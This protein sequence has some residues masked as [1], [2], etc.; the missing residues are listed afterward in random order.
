MHAAQKKVTRLSMCSNASVSKRVNI[1]L[2]A[3]ELF[4]KIVLNV[5]QV[6]CFLGPEVNVGPTSDSPVLQDQPGFG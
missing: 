6:F 1:G 4:T 2:K 5:C 3:L